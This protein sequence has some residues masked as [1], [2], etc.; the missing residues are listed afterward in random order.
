V[1]GARLTTR[2]LILGTTPY[3]EHFLDVF[4]DVPGVSFEGF[5][6]N[7]DRSRCGQTLAGLPILWNEA[8]DGMRDSHAL[9]CALATTHRKAWLDNLSGRGFRFATLVHP[10]SVVSRR[11]ELA[12]GVSVDAGSVIAGFS[13][14]G[15][16]VRV[17]RRASVGHHAVI[18]ACSTIHPGAVISGRC[19]IADQVMIGAGAVVIDQIS[20]G[21]GAVVAAG[22]VVTRDVPAGALVAGNPA[23]LK[24]EAYGPR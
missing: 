5:V 17:G 19:R 4:S 22:A 11:T 20:I 9:I 16:S 14:I 18:G 23:I 2:I 1:A 8:V 7:Q 3:G 13:R 6:E 24:R 10:S 21:A 12:P 15:A